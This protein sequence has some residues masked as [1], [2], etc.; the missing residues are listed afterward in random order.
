MP[1]RIPKIYSKQDVEDSSEAIQEFLDSGGDIRPSEYL[2][3]MILTNEGSESMEGEITLTELNHAFF[4]KMKGSS[5]PGID[6]FTVNWLRKFWDSLKLVTFDAINE[7]YRMQA[8]SGK[9]RR[10]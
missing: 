10:I 5:A 9:G 7:C 8:C 4:K 1:T 6:G 2:K 3:S